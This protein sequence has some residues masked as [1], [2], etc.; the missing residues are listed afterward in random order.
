MGCMVCR[1]MDGD[2]S[3]VIVVG[4]VVVGS[5]VVG[6]VVIDF[7]MCRIVDR[8]FGRGMVGGLVWDG[9]G[10]WMDGRVGI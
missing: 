10:S 8:V 9:F 1:I 7:V 6:M 3:G 2:V 5:D 4:V